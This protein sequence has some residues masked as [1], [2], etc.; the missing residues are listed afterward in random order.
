[1]DF[2]IYFSLNYHCPYSLPL[3]RRAE[4]KS[5]SEMQLLSPN[6]RYRKCSRSTLSNELGKY[7]QILKRARCIGKYLHNTKQTLTDHIQYMKLLQK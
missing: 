5:C 6:F 4:I 3:D 7:K 1:M 2:L